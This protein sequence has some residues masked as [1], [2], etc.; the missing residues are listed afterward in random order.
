[1]AL[2]IRPL[3]LEDQDAV[4]AV[5][6]QLAAWFRPID[7]MALAIDLQQHE[8]WVA[9]DEQAGDA[10]VGFLTYFM[11]SPQRAEISWFG[12]APGAQTSGIGG[13]LLRHAEAELR[14][15]G[16]RALQLNTIPEDADAAFRPT[17]RFYHHH[18]FTILQREDDFYSHGRPGILM[19]KRLAP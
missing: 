7:Q 8:G 16:V 18:G 13:Q 2:R 5:A 11:V 12:V 17:N 19:E 9:V 14:A 4:L 6:R 1:M 15:Q 10:V 3:A